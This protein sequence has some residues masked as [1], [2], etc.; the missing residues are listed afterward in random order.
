[1]KVRFILTGTIAA[2]AAIFIWG[3]ISHLVLPWHEWTMTLFTNSEQ[4]LDTVRTNAEQN[5][6]YFI[7][8]GVFAVVDLLPGL[9]DQTQMI[10]GNLALQFVTDLVV[11]FLLALTILGI[12]CRT[13]PGRAG[14][15]AM[16]GVAAGIAIHGAHWNWYGFTP[17]YTIVN[18]LDL[19]ISWFLAG[20]VLAVLNR[21]MLPAP[22]A[23]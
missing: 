14:F 10:G 15:T 1:M 20:M 7:N 21:K 23:A 3:S 5:G 4:V 11:A 9:P 6:I 2:A 22:D 8:E 18:T 19:A 12:S 17:A 13:I 16:L